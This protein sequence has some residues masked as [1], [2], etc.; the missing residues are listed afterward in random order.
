MKRK[1]IIFFLIT[2]IVVISGCTDKKEQ[3][4]LLDSMDQIEGMEDYEPTGEVVK[5]F[6]KD[7]VYEISNISWNGNQ[8]AAEV[9]VTTPDLKKIISDSIQKTIDEYGTEDYEVLLE[10]V[11]GNIQSTLEANNYP[12]FTS[13]IKMNAEKTGDGY[14]LISNEEFEKIVQGNLEEIFLNVLIEKGGED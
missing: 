10:N 2:L 6:S 11:K 7:I 14:T 3:V 12:T 9:K 8:G 5:A 4:R 13:N 1:I